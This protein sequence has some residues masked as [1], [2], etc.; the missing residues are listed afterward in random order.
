M[1]SEFYLVFSVQSYGVTVSVDLRFQNFFAFEALKCVD[2]H[3]IIFKPLGSLVCSFAIQTSSVLNLTLA[4]L[5]VWVTAVTLTSCK[6]WRS[7][8][9][10]QDTGLYWLLDLMSKRSP[11]SRSFRVFPVCPTYWRPHERQL[12]T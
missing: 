2:I 5:V 3:C 9:K 4:S 11:L 12:I 8:L 7:W 6:V 10:W 1:A